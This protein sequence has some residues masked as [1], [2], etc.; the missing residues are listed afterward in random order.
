MSAP[1][2]AF[3]GG[4]APWST[5][6][7]AGST[8]VGQEIDVRHYP[9]SPGPGCPLNRKMFEKRSDL[10]RF[11]AVVEA[12]RIATAADR[13]AITQPALT[14]I[15]IRLERQFGGKLFERLPHGVRLTA[16]GA[17]AS[18]VARRILREIEAAESILD[19]ARSGRTGN[20]RITAS[21]VWIETVLPA[22]LA[23]FHEDYPG[24]EITID[25]AGRAEGLRLLA[26]GE[27]D[28]HCGGIDAGEILP[29]S[30][31]RERFLEVTAGI[32]AWRGHPLFSLAV[33]DQ[34]LV[35]Y[36]WIDFC[37]DPSLACL[38][39]RLYEATNVRAKVVV[40]T[41]SASLCVLGGSPYLASLSFAFLDRLPGQ[42]L[43]PLPVETGLS[44]YRSGYVVRRSAEELPPFRCLAQIVR[45]TALA[46]SG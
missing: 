41:G 17:T 15:I 34:D 2:R 11:L 22:A 43:R 38:L 35:R 24:I 45:E 44:R 5:D 37:R 32:V 13:L 4:F 6:R 30:L 28:L 36:P 42:L 29:A 20:F 8:L 1:G 31:R 40:Q 46:R 7:R 9:N 33:S 25:M 27:S 26:D 23:R 10:V 18:S 19:A 14:R 3:G 39:D 21:P 12:G 16:L